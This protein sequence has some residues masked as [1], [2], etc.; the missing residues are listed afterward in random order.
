MSVLEESFT[1]GRN[2]YC[3]SHVSSLPRQKLRA[4][5]GAGTN[6]DQ[7]LEEARP[8]L[9]VLSPHLPLDPHFTLHS[10]LQTDSEAYAKNVTICSHSSCPLLY[11]HPVISACR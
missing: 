4:F 8:L 2:G 9:Y 7:R 5:G 10:T 1:V 6:R 3:V 11:R